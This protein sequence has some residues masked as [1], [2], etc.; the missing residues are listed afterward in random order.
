MV[1]SGLEVRFMA[2]EITWLRGANGSGK[3]SL[4]RML[5]GL[6]A[7]A[8]G[9]IEFDGAPL[10][11]GGPSVGARLRYLA[12]ANA[13]KDD[14]TLLESLSYLARL[15]AL[16]RPEARARAALDRLGLGPQRGRLVRTL[17]QGQRRRGAVARLALDEGE[18]VWLLD[19]PYDALD[20]EGAQRL[21]ALIEA[22]AARGGTVVLT[23]HGAP[24]LKN[25]S[26]LDLAPGAS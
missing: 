10:H 2:Q 14:L 17:S 6:S 16:D 15:A 12:H 13:L 22:H 1:F 9:R 3:T 25:M 21:S 4:L 26:T 5:A 20:A 11:A 8:A 24:S 7:P 18:G 23:S 19:E